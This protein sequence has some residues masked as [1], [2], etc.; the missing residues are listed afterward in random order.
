MSQI[1][2][3]VAKGNTKLALCCSLFAGCF[4]V[5]TLK[6]KAKAKL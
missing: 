4:Q 5:F 2:A 6:V 3:E 1:V